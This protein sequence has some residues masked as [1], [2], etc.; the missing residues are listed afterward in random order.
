[1]P[2]L[3]ISAQEFHHPKILEIALEIVADL[4]EKIE[5]TKADNLCL[6]FRVPENLARYFKEIHLTNSSKH[7][8]YRNC[9]GILNECSYEDRHKNL[10]DE[11]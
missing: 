2:T 1:M 9:Y 4:V 8:W 10:D 7:L 11:N 6:D 3:R 5:Y